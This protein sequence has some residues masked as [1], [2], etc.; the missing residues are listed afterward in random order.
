MV[1]R[2]RVLL[3]RPEP[4]ATRTAATLVEHGFSP[5]VLPLTAIE[6]VQPPPITGA[7]DGVAVTSANAV[8]H[9]PVELIAALRPLPA[10]AVGVQ[11]AVVLREAGFSAVAQ[12][13]G[14]AE[15]LAEILLSRFPAEARLAYL[16]G[17][18]RKPQ[19]EARL[20]KAGRDFEAIETYKTVRVAIDPSRRAAIERE[21][22][23]AALVYS[24][25][26]ATALGDV[27]LERDAPAVR[28]ATFVCLS[29]DVAQALP[30]GLT[31]VVADAPD[32]TS[33]LATLNRL[34]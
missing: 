2:A 33:L 31:I 34:F 1:N 25:A 5:V 30:S 10:L 27:L 20:H 22:F 3:T 6:T 24:A 4:G 7:F 17:H 19:L 16:C 26:S 13:D 8:R 12:A 14:T 23:D 11:T 18:P 15:A 28:R 29:F 21:G 9:A 32:E